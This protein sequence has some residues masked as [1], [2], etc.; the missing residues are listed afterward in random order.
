MS[1]PSRPPLRTALCLSLLIPPEPAQVLVARR[2][3]RRW[4]AGGCFATRCSC[5]RLFRRG[6]RSWRLRSRYKM[7]VPT[8][9]PVRNNLLA[10]GGRT[11][12]GCVGTGHAG[13]ERRGA[14]VLVDVLACVLHGGRVAEASGL[15]LGARVRVG[16]RAPFDRLRAN[17]F[18]G[19]ACKGGV[20]VGC[21]APLDTGFRRYDDGGVYGVSERLLVA[22]WEVPAAAGR[23]VREPPLRCVWGVG[24]ATGVGGGGG[25]PLWIPAFAGTTMVGCSG[26]ASAVGGGMG[27][28]RCCGT[29][30]S[31][32][33]PTVRLG[34]RR[35]DGGW[36]WWPAPL[37]TGFRRYD[38]G[39]CA[40]RQVLL[41]AEWEVPAA[42]GRAVREPPLRCV[43]GVGDATGVGGGGPRPAPLWI[44]AF[45]GTT[46]GGV[47]GGEC[48]WWR[49]TLRQAQGK[50][51]CEV[52]L[53]R[54]VEEGLYFC[55]GVDGW[56][57]F[58]GRV[59]WGGVWVAV[60]VDGGD[61][62]GHG[63]LDVA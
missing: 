17:G 2:R 31:R 51:V 29:G 30:G 19:R 33:D 3:G 58:G 55:E 56:D 48:C 50:R 57:A 60:D 53:R 10:V 61:A 11:A 5:G 28:S 35:C 41:A 12:H 54:G 37:D 16:G 59:F 23:A 20:V 24:D 21:P 47:A 43:W 36:W 1:S 52:R 7:L 32:T 8:F 38:D 13:R 4:A 49:R 44:P 27:S 39:G 22:E 63:T 6:G 26:S 42:A 15:A 45:A 18:V 40:G 62:Y 14:V 25:P 34:S 9:A 46:M